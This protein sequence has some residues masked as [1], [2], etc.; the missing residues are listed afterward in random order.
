MFQPTNKSVCI[1]HLGEQLTFTCPCTPEGSNT[2][3]ADMS[4]WSQHSE[5][6]R[7]ISLPNYHRQNE[8]MVLLLAVNKTAYL[9]CSTARHGATA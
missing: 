7:M 6:L 2:G 9:A 5:K 8:H 4:V 3:N 1:C